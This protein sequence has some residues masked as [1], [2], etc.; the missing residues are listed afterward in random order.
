M[1]EDEYNENLDKM[2]DYFTYEWQDVREV[3]GN[4]VLWH[5]IREYNMP[6][7]FN[8]GFKDALA[9]GEEIY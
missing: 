5:Y 2:N 1:S 4:Q 9:V 8:S 7:L 3:R 6:L